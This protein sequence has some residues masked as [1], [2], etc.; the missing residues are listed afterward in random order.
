MSFF[1]RHRFLNRCYHR[2]TDPR[3]YRDTTRPIEHATSIIS[4]AYNSAEYRSVEQ[5]QIHDRA[6]VCIGHTAMLN[7]P[8]DVLSMRFNHRN[9]LVV[10]E[11]DHYQGLYNTCRHRGAELLPTGLHQGKKIITCP[12]HAWGYQRD[13]SLVSTPY[14]D[15][16]KLP[17]NKQER[18]SR[19]RRHTTMPSCANQPL[20]K[21]QYH[22]YRFP[23]KAV[24]PLLFS[25]FAPEYKSLER[26]T[27]NLATL[28]RNLPDDLQV[29]HSE[30]LTINANW[31]LIAEN[32]VE[33]YHLPWVHPELCEVS[34]VANHG[35]SPVNITGD[36]CCFVTNPLTYSGTPCDP[37]AFPRFPDLTDVE[38][39]SATFVH[40]F[41]NVSM[42]IYPHHVVLLITE[43]V[44]ANKTTEQL[45]ILMNHKPEAT[46]LGRLIE[47][48]RTVNQQDIDI[49]ESVQRGIEN[50]CYRG[51]VFTPKFERSTYEFQRQVIQHMT[52]NANT[53]S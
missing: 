34:S 3:T 48:Y 14:F 27:G 51:G 26:Q 30:H 5:Q 52:D 8:G 33:Y 6:W 9:I 29:V 15:N 41:P 40:A 39:E 25:N 17:R 49:V 18:R 35:P 11:A 43:P 13:G 45:V 53:K 31:K 19:E 10:K 37:D 1:F 36:Y 38:R 28:F 47:F 44:T 22:L 32:F 20:D 46:M 50:A 23:V 2:F 16:Q 4:E 21:S 12:Y 7:Y 24:G 42:F